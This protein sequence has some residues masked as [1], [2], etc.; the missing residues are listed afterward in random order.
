MAKG[1]VIVID[2]T[3]GSGKHTQVKKMHERLLSENEKVLMIEYPRYDSDSSA[4][5]KMYLNGEFGKNPK[6]INPYVASSFY[7]VDRIADYTKYWKKYYDEGYIIIADRYTTANMVHQAGKIHDKAERTKLLDWIQDFEYNILG[8]PKPDL[9]FFIDVPP[10]LNTKLMD[11]RE[12][13]DIHEKD[14]NHLRDSYNN[15]LELVQDYDWH[16]LE[17]IKDGKL[18]TID[19]VHEEVYNSFIAYKNYHNVFKVN[20]GCK[21]CV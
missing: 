9:I 10:E 6:V 19:D 13:K 17:C 18:R 7:A 16:R 12:F 2:G 5:V 21:K 11:S 14:I 8:L 1:M 4:L 3:D 20:K 15:A